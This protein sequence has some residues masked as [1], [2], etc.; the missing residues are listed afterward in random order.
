METCQLRGVLWQLTCRRLDLQSMIH[1]NL[2]AS[3]SEPA[4]PRH[5]ALTNTLPSACDADGNSDDEAKQS[6]EASDVAPLLEGLWQDRVRDHAQHRAATKALDGSNH[7]DHGRVFLAAGW[8]DDG[9]QAG[10]QAR[11]HRDG[12]PHHQDDPPAHA[13]QPHRPRGRHRLRE[14]GQ[15]DAHDEG[16][17]GPLGRRVH[18]NPHDEALRHTVDEDAQPN[19]DRGL[20]PSAALV[21]MAFFAVCRGRRGV[22]VGQE[23]RE[24]P[25]GG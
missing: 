6:G 12:G 8:K 25:V 18:Q 1:A 15:E 24:V 17:K 20:H 5:P 3:S 2:L 22:L 19:H 21:P 23:V 4:E 10:P 9:A 11:H 13:V 7:L 16:Q 14:V